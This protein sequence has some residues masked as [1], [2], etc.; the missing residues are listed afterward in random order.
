M[1]LEK[2]FGFKENKINM[3]DDQKNIYSL[4]NADLII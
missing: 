4:T 2:S 3:K 1:I